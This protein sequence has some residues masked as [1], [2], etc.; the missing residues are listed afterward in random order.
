MFDPIS[1]NAPMTSAL[2]Y[3]LT[4][5]FI[6]A[7]RARDTAQLQQRFAV[8]AGSLEEIDE[9]LAR[10]ALNPM[11]LRMPGWDIAFTENFC[12]MAP[13]DVFERNAPRTW[14]IECTLY[15]DGHPTEARLTAEICD[16]DGVMQWRYHGL[17]S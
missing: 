3:Q 4:S 1:D 5:E 17:T 11:T 15:S 9:E 12:G 6:A 10:Y 16:V 7:L 13:F 14:G 2:A 8:H